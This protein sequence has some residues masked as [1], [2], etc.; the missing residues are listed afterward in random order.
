MSKSG[1]PAE[2]RRCGCRK[3]QTRCS[4][5]AHGMPTGMSSEHWTSFSTLL[6]SRCATSTTDGIAPIWKRLPLWA[7]SMRAGWKKR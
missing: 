7:I 6:H 5:K 2:R 3:R 1:A 4:I